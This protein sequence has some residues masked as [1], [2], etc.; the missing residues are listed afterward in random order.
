LKLLATII[1][2]LFTLNASAEQISHNR[3]TYDVQSEVSEL[4]CG[5]YMI[6]STV[7][8]LPFKLRES[9]IPYE[10][11]MGHY[12]KPHVLGQSISYISDNAGKVTFDVNEIIP[13]YGRIDSARKYLAKP[14]ACVS[15]NSVVFS[16]W[17][18]GNCKTV[19]EAWALVKFSTTGD[20]IKVQGLSYSEFKQYN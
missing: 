2:S 17:G 19:C 20:P 7:K 1:A 13:S 5:P 14:E 3:T 16:F 8:T 9:Q 10:I 12:G 6:I 4:D 11:T 18:G 15:Q